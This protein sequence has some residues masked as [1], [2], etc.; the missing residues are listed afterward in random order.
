MKRTS[1]RTVE[2]IALEWD[3]IAPIRDAQISSGLDLSYN[4][5]LKSMIL[6]LLEP[7]DLTSV[8]DLGC[9]TGQL[10]ASLAERATHV[11]GIDIS[12][13][14]VSITAQNTSSFSNVSLPTISLGDSPEPHERSSPLWSLTCHCQR[15]PA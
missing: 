8:L 6:R 14:S 2:Q 1:G 4:T 12:A 9:G 5:V 10:I 15:L 13:Q 3:S 11:T 7:V